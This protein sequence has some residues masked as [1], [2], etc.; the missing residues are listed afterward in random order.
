MYDFGANINDRIAW[1]GLEVALFNANRVSLVGCW[2][3]PTTLTANRALWAQSNTSGLVVGGTTSQVIL[4]ADTA[5][6]DGNYTGPVGMVVNTLTF[7]AVLWN[8]GGTG[9]GVC[10]MWTATPTSGP[11]E[12][13]V[14]VTS[15]PTGGWVGGGTGFTVGNALSGG[16]AFQGAIGGV[17]VFGDL[18]NSNL[19][20]ICGIPANGAISQA[21]TDSVRAALVD[22]MWRG[23]IAKFAGH[24]RQMRG[25]GSLGFSMAASLDNAL[26][27]GAWAI[28]S[29]SAPNLG[30]IT[31]A[32][33]SAFRTPHSFDDN[34]YNV[35]SRRRSGFLVRN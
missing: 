9:T 30:T 22:P 14:T 27:G 8:L 21:Q 1:T 2:V 15:T 29:N 18:T 7:I 16:A 6:T 20:A 13:S 5:T 24:G 11:V 28:R 4:V 25:T 10:K 34:S 17:S 19:N 33:A 31:S 32:T 23:D 35:Y 12:V 26:A 3:R